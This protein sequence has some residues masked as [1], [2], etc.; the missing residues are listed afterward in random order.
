MD[1]HRPFDWKMAGATFVMVAAQG[2]IQYGVIVTQVSEL[3]RRVDRIEQKIDDKMMPREE[4]EKRHT[5]LERR[6]EE[7]RERVQ[8]LELQGITTGRPRAR[9]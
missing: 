7:L 8:Q 2:L 6:M 5:E 1:D 9:Q 3:Q 4:F